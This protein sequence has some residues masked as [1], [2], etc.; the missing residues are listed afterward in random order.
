MDEKKIIKLDIKPSDV[1]QKQPRQTVNSSLFQTNP[2]LQK[3]FSVN[4]TT[5]KNKF[6]LKDLF[7]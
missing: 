2:I 7:R 5:K 1:E 6:N 4:M 3:M